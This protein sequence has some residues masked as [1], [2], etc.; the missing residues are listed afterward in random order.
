M[1]EQMYIF[2]EQAEWHER[3][4]N[5]YANDDSPY[6]QGAAQYHF[7]KA[8]ECW[9]KY[10]RLLAEAETKEHW[11]PEKLVVLPGRVVG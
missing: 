1:N 3:K 4:A 11:K 2:K 5:K 9:N 8:Q 6:A 7:E 10:G